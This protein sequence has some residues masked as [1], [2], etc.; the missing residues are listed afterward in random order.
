MREPGTVIFKPVSI[1]LLQLE[2]TRLYPDEFE[3][4]HLCDELGMTQ[5]QAGEQMGIS[6]G[7]VQRLVVNGRRKLIEALREGRAIVLTAEESTA[8][9]T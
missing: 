1:P 8:Q 9:S 4:M 3:A 5:Q 6:R 2:E 7:T